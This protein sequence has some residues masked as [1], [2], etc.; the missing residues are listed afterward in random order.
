MRQRLQ[1]LRSNVSKEDLQLQTDRKLM[2]V[3]RKK[4]RKPIVG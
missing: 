4:R 3:E 1:A 2:E